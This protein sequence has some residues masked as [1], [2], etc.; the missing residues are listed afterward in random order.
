MLYIPIFKNRCR[1]AACN[2]EIGYIAYNYTSSLDNS[3]FTYFHPSQ[4]NHPTAQP[5]II[6]NKNILV[7]V[8]IIVRD[9]HSFIKIMEMSNNQALWAGMKIITY[10]NLTS[11]CNTHSVKIYIVS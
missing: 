2:S 7:Y 11:T 3:P 8:S 4:D 9:S 10:N 6:P 1:M 5:D